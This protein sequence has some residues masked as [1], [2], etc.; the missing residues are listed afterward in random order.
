[1]IL[2]ILFVIFL[3]L[4]FKPSNECFTINNYVVIVA[5][6]NEDITW[7]KNLKYKYIIYEKL[8]KNSKYY[9]PNYANEATTYLKYICDNYNNLPE[10][11]I[12]LHGENES[13]HHDGKITAN[14]DKYILNYEKN[15]NKFYNINNVK[16]GSIKPQISNMINSLW[17]PNTM[18]PWFGDIA[19]Y[20]DFTVGQLC[21]AQFIVSRKQIKKLP[22]DFYLNM[23]TWL[24]KN[25]SGPGN[26]SQEDINSGYNTS[27]YLEWTWHLIFSK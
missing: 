24:I 20:N 7:V 17:W 5:H 15:N 19:N 22:L 26:G 3:Y 10:N 23:Y 16:L 9:C 27:R 11:I 1:M 12:M 21:C 6:Y 2:K 8:K 4:I 13:W 18:E 14:I 25:T